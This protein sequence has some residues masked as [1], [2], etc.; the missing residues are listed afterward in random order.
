MIQRVDFCCKSVFKLFDN[1]NKDFI[2]EQD[3]YSGFRRLRIQIKGLVRDLI[4]SYG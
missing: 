2:T 3:F 1:E 4:L